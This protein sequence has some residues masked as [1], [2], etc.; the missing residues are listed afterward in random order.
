MSENYENVMVFSE[1]EDG[2]IHPVTYELLGKGKE[3]AEKLGEELVCVIAGNNMEKEDLNELIYYGADKVFLFDDPIFE[4]LNVL[5][6]S[7]NISK[8]LE[9]ESPAIVLFGATH[10]GRSLGPRIAAN[11]GTGLTADCTGL[12]IDDEDSLI[13]IRPAFSGNILAHIKTKTRPQMAT[14]RY[15]V[16][17]KGKRNESR[18]GEIIKKEPYFVEE[19]ERLRIVEMEE[20]DTINI[21]DSEIIVSGGRGLEEADDFEIIRNLAEC[22][23][24]VVGSSRPLVDMG[25]IGKDHQVGFSGNTVKPSI[26]IACGIS[27]QPQHLAGMRDSDTIIAINKDPEAPIFDFSDYGIVGDLYD[28][29]PIL[30]EKIRDIKSE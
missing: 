6:Y 25:W 13:Q 1:Q 14:V 10:F 24:G 7:K 23:G 11:L 12:E 18:D 20:K 16:M 27:G 29:V 28:V 22:L 2:Q 19:D 5:H 26:Y 4:N 8:F 30:C 17:E 9:E 21:A 15:K 3:L